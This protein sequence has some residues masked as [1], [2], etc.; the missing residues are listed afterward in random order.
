VIVSG[1]GGL[2]GAIHALRRLV[3]KDG[4]LQ[5]LRAREAYRK[6]G[7]RRRDKHRKAIRRLKKS[8]ARQENFRNRRRDL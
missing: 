3:T 6:P 7:V 1:D 8:E 5:A 2:E 4:L